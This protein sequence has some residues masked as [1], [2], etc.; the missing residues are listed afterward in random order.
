[1]IYGSPEKDSEKTLLN[2]QLSEVCKHYR[3]CTTEEVVTPVLPSPLATPLIFSITRK[4]REE[5]KD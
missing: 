2:F 5:K 1:M 3:S 4:K